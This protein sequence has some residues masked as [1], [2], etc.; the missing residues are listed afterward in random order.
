VATSATEVCNLALAHLGQSETVADLGNENESGEVAALCRR[1]YPVALGLIF[2]QKGVKWPFA[3]RVSY[4]LTLVA[5]DL[6][7]AYQYSFRLPSDCAGLWRVTTPYCNNVPYA[8]GG[9]AL[10]QLLYVNDPAISI[11]YGVVVEN[12]TYWSADFT[13]ALSYLL[14]KLLVPA[15]TAGDPYKLGPQVA[16]LYQETVNGAMQTAYNE[17]GGDDPFP[18]TILESRR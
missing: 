14:A 1:F 16:A 7:G 8:L 18:N 9:D 5:D 17:A 3:R 11:E 15:L 12:P 13:L 10:G 6:E 4:G 2:R